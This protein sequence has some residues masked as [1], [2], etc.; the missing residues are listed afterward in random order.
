MSDARAR[1]EAARE[2]YQKHY[3]DEYGSYVYADNL[4]AALTADRDAERNENEAVTKAVRELCD[5][6]E[7]DDLDELETYIEAL[8]E[9]D[10]Y[11]G[12]LAWMDKH[13]PLDVPYFTESEDVGC[14]VMRLSRKVMDSEQAREQAE[15]EVERL[16]E[17]L[18]CAA[19]NLSAWHE[20]RM[21]ASMVEVHKALYA[22]HW[23]ARAEEGSE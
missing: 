14:Q 13:Y 22:E 17:R 15:A 18:Q 12:H 16:K 2:E 20:Y 1:A 6:F 21:P 10:S 11:N 5:R 4:I 9:L 23:T 3:L 19:T 7:C 8:D